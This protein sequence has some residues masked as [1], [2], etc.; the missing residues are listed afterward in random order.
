MF[1]EIAIPVPNPPGIKYLK[2]KLIL[3]SSLLAGKILLTD[4]KYGKEVTGVKAVDNLINPLLDDTS[5]LLNESCQSK[6][7]EKSLIFTVVAKT[8]EEKEK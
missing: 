8:F 5:P 3:I 4:L 1:G 2:L 7:F 6:G